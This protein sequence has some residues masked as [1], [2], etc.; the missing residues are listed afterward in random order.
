[1]TVN[2]NLVNSGGGVIATRVVVLGDGEDE[3]VVLHDN[4]VEA[5]SEWT[6]AVG[7]TIRIEEV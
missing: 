5:I 4:M 3:S 1:M 7:D 2:I 6:L